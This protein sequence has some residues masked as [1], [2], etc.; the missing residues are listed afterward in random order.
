MIDIL[1]S[2]YNGELF[3]RQ[4]LESVIAQTYQD[5][6]MLIRDDGSCD[7]TLAI[8]MEFCELYPQKIKHIQGGKNIGCL[9]SFEILLEKSKAPY[10]MFCDQDDV[11]LPTK[12]E[13]EM[14]AMLMLEKDKLQIPCVICSDLCVVDTQLNLLDSSYWHYSRINPHLLAKPNAIA[15]TNYVTGCTMLMNAAVKQIALPF[16]QMA[17][18]H[19]AWIALRVISQNGYIMALNEANILY[20]QHNNNK[21]GAGYVKYNWQYFINK[22]LHIQQVL[23]NNYKNYKQA[24]EIIGISLLCFLYNRIKYLIMR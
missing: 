6:E 18:M 9:R 16:G 13:K 1:L 5:W 10:I 4:Q 19:D 3:L 17:I 21:V 23:V 12:I 2:T 20:R 8:I 24:H 7:G 14:S 11:W 22:V 15:V